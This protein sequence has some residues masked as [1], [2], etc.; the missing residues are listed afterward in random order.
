[1]VRPDDTIPKSPAPPDAAR[2]P[3]AAL[4]YIG[5]VD[6]PDPKAQRLVWLEGVDRVTIE[7][8]KPALAIAEGRRDEVVVDCPRGALRVRVRDTRV[9][10][11]HATLERQAGTWRLRDE[12]SKNGTEVNG[13]RVTE[14]DLRH[15]DI[16]EMGDTF[17]RYIE[18][19]PLLPALFN[20]ADFLDF[21]A[22]RTISPALFEVLEPLRRAAPGKAHLLIMGETGSGKEIAVKLVHEWSGRKGPCHTINCSLS[23]PAP[24][25]FLFGWLKG[26]FTGAH[27]DHEGH[28]EASKGG[29]LVLDEIGTLPLDVQAKLLRVLEDGEVYRMGDVHPRHVDLRVVAATNSDIPAMAL[30]GTFR[31]DLRA[32]LGGHETKLPPLRDRPEDVG[33]LV[34]QFLLEHEGG[35]A[36]R[37]QPLAMR[38][39]LAYKWPQ[40][41]RQ[42]RSVIQQAV[43]LARIRGV[44]EPDHLT[45]P[46]L[47]DE[48][49]M[50]A[51]TEFCA[52]LDAS[53]R[54]HGG[55]VA[56]VGRDLGIKREML[57]RRMRA[58]K[59][60]PSRYRGPRP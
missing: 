30:D 19:T 24:G 35:A 29:T 21:G 7:R 20:R 53:L 22:T 33:G 40:N 9:S 11:L 12:H 56:K 2:Q 41:V 60:D 36:I 54:K 51:H 15:G 57:Y 39:L 18:Y 59:L 44:L 1:V 55:N 6:L 3:L 28:I 50:D 16:V 47:P 13:Q 32:R 43:P 10:G 46:P 38:K 26:A 27:S 58:C 37:I 34:A 25:A 8:P 4:A 5:W 31:P 42:L 52:R 48:P 45:L 17:W 23:D 49:A 14:H